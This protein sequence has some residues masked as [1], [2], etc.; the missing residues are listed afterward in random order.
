MNL[1]SRK[2]PSPFGIAKTYLKYNLV[3]P[4]VKRPFLPKYLVIYVTYRCNAQ[5][6]MCGIWENNASHPISVELTLE[7]LDRILSDRL[8]SQIESLN[9]QGGELTLRKDLSEMFQ[10]C[11]NRLP[12][13]RE[14]RMVSNGL[15]T[16]RLVSQ[17]KQ[18]RE[19]CATKKVAFS[20]CVSVHGLSG[21]EDKVYGTKGAFDKQQKT[22]AALKEIAAQGNFKLTLSCVIQNE[23]LHELQPLKQWSYDQKLNLGFVVVETRERFGNL[24]KVEQFEIAPN[25]K[26]KVIQFFRELSRPGGVSKTSAYVY[27]YIADLMEFNKV[28]TM[29]CDYYLGGIILG[30][31]GELYYCPHSQEIGN[32][33]DQSAYDIYYDP[34]NL[35]YRKIVLNQ[36]KCLHCPPKELGRESIQTDLFKYTRFLITSRLRHRKNPV[37]LSP[38]PIPVKE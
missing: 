5:C 27:D 8:F 20:V 21:I 23:N 7:D 34:H 4:L 28:R 26:P 33:R 37:S 16:D 1:K 14:I 11:V 17:V 31:Q 36:K 32:C 2:M 35:E 15:L 6:I 18:I 24:E 30:S 12:A 19:I 29:S 3:Q 38:K 22:I 9:F 10:V 25:N 13:L